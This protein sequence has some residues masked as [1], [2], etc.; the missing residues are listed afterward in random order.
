MDELPRRKNIRLKNYD[1]SQ[2][3]Y[4]FI[5]IC[6]KDKK[7]LFWEV[8]AT[9]GRQFERPPLSNIGEIIDLEINKINSIY[10]NVEINKYV[11][12]PNHIHMIIILYNGNGRSKTVPTISRIIQ[13]FKGSISK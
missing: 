11:I 13:Q 3:G 7:S 4:Y 8:G 12:M 5:T 2:A 1:Y 9:C 10:E 6:S